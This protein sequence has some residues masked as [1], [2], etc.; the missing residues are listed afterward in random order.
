MTADPFAPA[1]DHA[2]A[3]AEA[4]TA[5]SATAKF[6]KALADGKSDLFK[7]NPFLIR[8]VPGFNSRD[9]SLPENEE[10]VDDLARSIATE[11]VKKPIE[12]RFAEDGQPDLVD[13]EC[14]L[15]AVVRAI[16]VYGASELETVPVILA[17]KG[18]NDADFLAS[19]FTSNMGK[20][21][22]E[23]EAAQ[24]VRRLIDFGWDE[25]R[26]AERTG[27]SAAKVARLVRVL[28][29]P[30]EIKGM[31]RQDQVSVTQALATIQEQS[32]SEKAVEAL[33]MGLERATEA[34]KSK[35]TAKHVA[36][37]S[38]RP[39][40]SQASALSSLREAFRQ[41]E[42]ERGDGFVT[43]TLTEAGAALVKQH[44]GV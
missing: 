16:N 28:E 24:G 3:L 2:R 32:T 27:M 21:F 12:V 31:V 42:V 38:E 6:A 40:A 41:A 4:A 39:G 7:L 23:L 22:N 9:F 26:I 15:R 1:S 44:F 10:H 33:K 5:K 14:R 17:P 11:G 35:V 29:M 25:R 18:R 19:Q 34:G 8:V 43:Y 30:E 13:G 20:R 36:P 37:A